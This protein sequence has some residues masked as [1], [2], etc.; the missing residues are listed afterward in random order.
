MWVRTLAVTLSNLVTS[1]TLSPWSHVT[2]DRE[3]AWLTAFPPT[4]LHP[5]GLEQNALLF[6]K[7]L[8]SWREAPCSRATLGSQRGPNVSAL[9]GLPPI[10]GFSRQRKPPFVPELRVKNPRRE[11]MMNQTPLDTPC[12]SPTHTNSGHSPANPTHPHVNFPDQDNCSTVLPKT[13]ANRIDRSHCW[14]MGAA[15]G[16]VTIVELLGKH[17]HGAEMPRTAA[18]GPGCRS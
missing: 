7:K 6:G 12:V 5:Q 15:R 8:A 13:W 10:L 2:S 9:W 16:L 18:R 11:A 4:P 1:S 14:D 17:P 3:K